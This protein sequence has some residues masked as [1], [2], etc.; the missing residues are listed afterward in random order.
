MNE[1]IEEPAGLGERGSRMWRDTLA[2]WALTPAH[3]VLLEEA[4]RTADRLD[5]LNAMLRS[6]TGDVNP[7]APQFADIQGLLA[8]IRQ[9][10]GALKLLLAE[11]RQGQRSASPA[12]AEPGAS[13]KGV[14]DL[15]AR[16]ARKRR[17]AEQ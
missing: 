16:I 9:Q 7:D 14:T 12:P 8:E 6:P 13:S 4:C 15:S 2:I 1:E 17:Q 10:A 5:V 11:I 3:L